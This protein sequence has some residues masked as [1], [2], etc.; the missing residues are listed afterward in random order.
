MNRRFFPGWRLLS[1][2]TLALLLWQASPPARAA[3]QIQIVE[4]RLEQTAE[5]YELSSSF[6]FT[7]NPE[8]DDALVRGIPLYFTTD[9]EIV[10]PRWYWFDQTAL[11][12]S[13]TLR[14]SYNLLTRQ[15]RVATAGSLH[16][17]FTTLDEALSLVQRPGRWLLAGPDKL[18]AGET[19]TVSVHMGLDVAK[20]PKPFQ[21]NALSSREWDLTSDWVRFPFQVGQE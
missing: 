5:G 12:A 15:Y 20:L 2:L 21:V 19:Y 13:R 10:Q 8:L 4:I 9:V 11:R 16:Q 14:L 6:D 18:S 17:N 3:N 1:F 7:L